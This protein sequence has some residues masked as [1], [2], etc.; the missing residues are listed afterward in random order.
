MNSL[1]FVK[2]DIPKEKKISPDT[3]FEQYSE[4]WL[5]LNKPFLSPKTYYRYLAL[6]KIINDGIGHIRMSKIEAYHLQMY[7]NNLSTAAI[8][9]RT[10][11]TLSNKTIIHHHRLISVIIGQAVREG[12]L[13]IN[14]AE[15]SYLRLPKLQKNEARYLS[16]EEVAELLNL[17]KKE[18]IK[19]RTVMLLLLY[20][21]MRR[22]ELCGLEWSDINFVSKELRIERTSQYLPEL[23][24]IT[25]CTKTASSTRTIKIS[26]EVISILQDYRKWWISHASRSEWN[27]YI[28]VKYSNGISEIIKN[29]RLFTQ[30]N[31]YPIHPDSISDYTKKFCKK[32]NFSRFSPHALRHTNISLLVG[33]QIPI[34][35][36]AQR[37]G[38]AQPTTTQNVYT[39]LLKSCN[40]NTAEKIEE[41]ISALK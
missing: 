4:R 37:V 15:K 7:Y 31:G 32:Y 9:K 38:H 39:H 10:G 40:D 20:T 2:E 23:G 34:N 13:N 8:N 33:N 29:Q 26:N 17:L 1:L 21:G 14:I 6:L 25:K 28:E 22:G 27:N 18:H 16:E 19:W 41:I 30:W 3:T 24:I 5:E 36:V 11:G 35:Q 12:I